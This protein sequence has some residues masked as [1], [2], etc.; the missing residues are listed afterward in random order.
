M[1][2]TADAYDTTPE[3]LAGWLRSLDLAQTVGGIDIA[4]AGAA[5]VVYPVTEEVIA[6]APMGD[7]ETA[8]AAI[9]AA[10]TAFAA[11]ARTPWAERRAALQRFADAL[12]RD[13]VEL[14][15]VVTA[16]T[17]RPLRRAL[18]EV[19][20]GAIYVRTV[21][22]VPP[23]EKTVPHP[24]SR[25][26]MN[27]RPLGVVAA[28]APWNGPVIL[29]VVKI[30][31]AL[32][33]GNTIV[34][35]PS[36]FSPLSALLFGRIGREA[37]PPGVCNIVTGGPEVGARL[38]SHPAVAK[39]SFT[40]STA[41]GRRIGQTAAGNLARATL[42][43]GG[44]D[45]AIVLP[46]ADLEQFVEVTTQ[47]S[48]ANAGA[49]CSAIKRAYVHEDVL[50]EVVDR[51]DARLRRLTWGDAFDRATD[52]TPVQNRPQYERV[53][54]FVDDAV[55]AGG[56]LHG[57]GRHPMTRGY[58]VEPSVVTGLARGHRL[59]VEEQF[60]PILPLLPFRDLDDVVAAADSGP[61]GLGAS[62]WSADEDRAVD[63]AESLQ[64]GTVWVNQHGAFEAG[65]PMPMAKD[66]GLGIDYA[67]YGVAEHS[68]A[69]VINIA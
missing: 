44:N 2:S 32:L 4:G 10:A 58:F 33:A 63:I 13:A 51:F 54:G 42:E 62:V 38:T 1:T 65:I 7:P 53:L 8:D 14:A 57:T 47:M 41:T 56:T 48:L 36:E 37:F 17:G 18:G 11:W 66:S 26:R 34:L 59:V 31:T 55:A 24:R 16:E 29:A 6:R 64:V 30:A 19:F 12:E 40:G 52:L 27:H 69:V 67:E 21:A 22:A 39:I 45:P 25:I 9:A 60:G 35:K 20:G 49:F 61:Y 46:D 3:D 50:D 28:I 23:F 15:T 5:D 68:Q 43:L